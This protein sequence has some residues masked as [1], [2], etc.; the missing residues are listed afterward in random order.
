[1]KQCIYCAE[2]IEDRAV[3]CK[4]CGEPQVSFE[5]R[6]F[7]QRYA[8]MPPHVRDGQLESLDPEQRAAFDLAWGVYGQGLEQAPTRGPGL[9][10]RLALGCLLVSGLGAALALLLLALYSTGGN[11]EAGREAK[12]REALSY[13]E[14]VREVAWLEVNNNNVYLG[15]EPAPSDLSIVVGGAALK[16][17]DAIGFG[18]HVWA[19][20]ASVADRSWRPGD[21]GFICNATARF[22]QVQKNSCR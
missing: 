7:C 9:G 13:V 20:D 4:H 6:D 15:F 14:S 16:A 22:G 18:A 10:V 3:K 12:I 2:E 19:V 11:S 17:N 21:R 8:R 1:M 5:W